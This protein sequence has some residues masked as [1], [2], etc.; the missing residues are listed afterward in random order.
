[1]SEKE[2]PSTEGWADVKVENNQKIYKLLQSKVIRLLESEDDTDLLLVNDSI[3]MLSRLEALSRQG[4]RDEGGNHTGKTIQVRLTKESMRRW[5]KWNQAVGE[6]LE[7][8]AP[9]AELGFKL[10]LS[11]RGA[12]GTITLFDNDGIT[13]GAKGFSPKILGQI[14]YIE[15]SIGGLMFEHCKENPRIT[16]E[17]ISGITEDSVSII[18]AEHDTSAVE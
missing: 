17:S 14:G 7:K 3:R 6:L 13:L 10:L 2:S 12:H 9:E 16:V 8:A 11:V 4:A 15:K 5:F 1:M 18:E